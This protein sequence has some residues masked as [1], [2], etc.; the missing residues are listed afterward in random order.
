[1][2]LAGRRSLDER[3]KGSCCAY[4][5]DCRARGSPRSITLDNGSEFAS[6]AME[7][8]AIETGVQLCFI[9][10]GRPVESGFIESFNGRLRDECLNVEW[11]TSV[12]EA[13]AK[14]SEWR[15]H[16]NHARLHSALD[17]WPQAVFAELHQE[18]PQRFALFQSTA[19]NSSPRQGSLCRLMPPLTRLAVCPKIS[20]IRAKRFYAS[21]RTEALS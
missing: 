9:R 15:N 16:Y 20:I 19:T 6:R 17:D 5:R 4:A 12:E 11:F 13:Q 14:L 1:M 8:W 21:P 3:A 10:P 18:S 2:H 7:M